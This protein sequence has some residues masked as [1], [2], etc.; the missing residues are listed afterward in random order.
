MTKPI[1]ASHPSCDNKHPSQVQLSIEE[2][3]DVFI[4]LVNR[5]IITNWFSGTPPSRSQYKTLRQPD[6]CGYRPDDNHSY[7]DFRYFS[8]RGSEA[9]A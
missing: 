4:A 3:H 6:S 5:E 8:Q 1:L 2:Q 7:K 9:K